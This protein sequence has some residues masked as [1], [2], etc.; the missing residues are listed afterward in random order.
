M[1]AL[2]CEALGTIALVLAGTGAIVVD[3]PSGGAIG[4][5]GVSLV[6][7]LVVLVLVNALG[8]TSGARLNPAVSMAF[9]A[10]VRF[11]WKN[12]PGYAAA[13]ILGAIGAS[14]TLSL[15]FPLDSRLGATIPS[16][17]SAQS[18]VLEVLLAWF[19][20]LVVLSMSDGAK[21]RGPI[22]GS[23]IG[24][25]VALAALFAGPIS[26]ASMNPARSIGPALVSGRIDDLWIYIAAPVVGAL[27]AI[28]CC[29]LV[30]LPG[31]C[32]P[33]ACRP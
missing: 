6:F 30:R 10:S 33:E 24:A 14:L 16:G 18:F 20:M 27:L 23:T 22:A 21:E 4:H 25:V 2:A 19:L 13:Q 9:A 3:G 32:G 29:R 1:R 17:S 5:L 8:D 12:V 26:G 11:A 31:C 15:L 7:G 28:P